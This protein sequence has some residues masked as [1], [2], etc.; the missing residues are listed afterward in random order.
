M[1]TASQRRAFEQQLGLERRKLATER[2]AAHR[3]IEDAEM[4]TVQHDHSRTGAEHRL[5]AR[6]EVDERLAKPL[7]LHA[8]P[9]GGGLAT[10]N[11]QGIDVLE[12]RRRTDL[13]DIDVQPSDLRV[14]LEPALEGEDA[15]ERR[16][17]PRF[18]SSP[19]FS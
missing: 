1:N 9:D 19:P 16:H 11:D 15:D 14:C 2:I 18:W 12:V 5:S 3:D 4:V 10:R 17:Q 7:T 6:D 8:E 13:P